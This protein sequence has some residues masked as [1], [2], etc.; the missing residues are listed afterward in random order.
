VR[1]TEWRLV[2]ALTAPMRAWSRPTQ[3]WVAAV[4]VAL[5]AAYAIPMAF[6][7]YPVFQIADAPYYLMIAHGDQAHVMKPFAARQLGALVA[8]G[9]A[10]LLHAGVER[11]FL[12]EGVLSFLFTL[13][14][15]YWLMVRTAAPRWMLAA[16]ILL[17]VWID[18]FNH[19]ALPDVWDAAL[20]L[21]FLLLLERRWWLA[22]GLMMLP[23]MVTRESTWLVLVCLL[24]VA[25]RRMGWARIAAAVSAAV[26]GAM[27]V[28]RLSRHSL[29][30]EEH[31]PQAVYMLAKGPWNLLHNV[32]GL[33]PWSNVNRDLCAVPMWQAQVHLGR[34]QAL[35]ICSY[36]AVPQL[37]VVDGALTLFGLLPLLLAML[38]WKHRRFAGRSVM[39]RFVLL[40]GAAS[41]LLAPVLGTDYRHLAGYSWPLFVVALPELFN[42]F[43]PRGEFEP[44]SWSLPGEAAGLAF[45]ALHLV[46][47]LLGPPSSLGE[48]VALKA[49]LWVA[50]WAALRLWM[51]GWRQ[52]SPVLAPAVV[53]A[54]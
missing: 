7:V 10:R 22:A 40:Y 48:D 42:E 43:A 31:L 23:L 50:G 33:A 16:M 26:A 32:F 1:P 46:T 19:L 6:R 13:A 45:C 53:T 3:L 52:P 30:N 4:C 39:L 9:I 18:T 28:G 29:D 20:L 38:W 54:S 15:V 21:L 41:Y 17:P 12:V 44:R 34:V 24:A 25:G 11:G 51:A 49:L 37:Q 14:G 47:V 27:I 2:R 8:A 5:C 35:G 36:S